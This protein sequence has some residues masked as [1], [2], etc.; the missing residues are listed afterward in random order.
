M[1]GDRMAHPLLISLTNISSEIRMKSSQNAFV[2]LALL[3]VPKFLHSDKKLRG[4]LHSR[5]IHAC[6]DF[7]L[8]PLKTAARIGIMLSDPLGF[9]RFCFTPC[10]AYMVDHEEAIMLA[11]V[12]GKT[13]HIT[14]A[15][16]KKFGDPFRH[17][18]RTGSHTLTQRT[19]IRAKARPDGDLSQFVKESM[20]FRL[21][22]V[23]KLFWRDWAGAEPSLFF[24]PEPLHYWHKQFWDH[25]AR[26]CI[27]AVGPEEIDFRFSIM[28][29]RIGFRQ[30]KEG[31]SKLKQVTGRE[32]RDVERYMVSIIS[33]AVPKD[34][35]IA[36]RALMDFRYLAQAP[37]IS[38]VDCDNIDNALREF[39]KHKASIL[40]AGAKVGKKNKPIDNWWIPKL[41]M[42]QSVATNIRANGAAFQWS[43]DITEHAHITEIKHPAKSGNNQNYDS[44]I[45]R[46]L[47]RTDKIHRFNLAT[48]IKTA[49]IIFGGR[50]DDDNDD[51]SDIEDNRSDEEDDC[52]DS[53]RQ[54]NTTSALL[55]S[56]DP[57]SP[58]AG[59]TRIVPNY[60][61]H[62]ESLLRGDYPKAPRP[63]RTFSQGAT[64]FQLPRDAS[65]K[66]LDIR[67]V[68]TAFSLIDF[69][70]AL[71][72]YLHRATSRDH[73]DPLLVIG[74][75]RVARADSSIDF[76]A[77]HV[78][79]RLRIQ[80]KQYH[81]PDQVTNPRTLVA[82]P[83]CDEWP[84][85]H[86]DTV[87][88]NTDSSKEW[89]NSGIE[90]TYTTSIDQVL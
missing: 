70:P 46:S 72:D 44:Q 25:D 80:L 2:L 84:A 23:D 12:A 35:V 63:Y 48:S 51:E 11:G 16:Y 73:H 49:G 38:D 42:M 24:T 52:E 14:V 7:V 69:R 89:P 10:A 47:D 59:R 31:I 1:T 45:C 77:I 33:G 53:T 15:D 75:R 60:F 36:I 20:K 37:V 22:G 82:S 88:V 54:I 26:W 85:G 62:A 67:A 87:L 30:F 68:S 74:G 32:H 5:L 56:I 55:V 28:P 79:N 4:V 58:L 57:A 78:W 76:D 8:L 90:G 83:P 39:H 18:P 27:R 34:F 50:P 81:R 86:Y 17:E 43:A 41:E 61:K 66:T 19:I 64:A 29:Y 40:N 9:R 3:P 21:N 13:S 6:L 65:Y 71:I